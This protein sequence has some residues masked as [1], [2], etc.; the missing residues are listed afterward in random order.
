MKALL[1]ALTI[2]T[3]VIAPVSAQQSL[4]NVS[5]D[6][7]RE[8]YAEFNKTFAGNWKQQ[9][10]EDVT[11]RTSH[12]GSGAQARA[13]IDGLEADVVTLAL[14]YDID[15]IAEKAKLLPPDW[16][17]RLPDNSSP[18]TSTIV[19]LVRAGNPKNIKDWP[20]L[21]KPGVKVITPNPKTSGAARWAYLAAWGYA[22]KAPGGDAAKA[23]EFVRQLYSHVPVL[24][25]GARGSTMTFARRG[26]GD[27][28][29]S[30]ENEA[31]LV[32]AESGPRK[33]E[34]V[35]PSVSILAVPPVAIVDKVVDRRGTRKL[36]QRWRTNA[37]SSSSVTGILALSV[38]NAAPTS[39]SRG[40]GTPTTCAVA[41]AGC[42]SSTSSTSAGA[43]FSPPTRKVSLTRP[44]M[45]S[46][47]SAVRTPMSPVRN[48]PPGVSA[49]A[50][51][52][53]FL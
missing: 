49:L 37:V 14:A 20:D 27:V 1:F 52:S 13:V 4:L 33:F 22:L 38:T 23:R 40:S 50:V 9:T 44:T 39:P 3:A 45:R 25:S 36:A 42:A 19:F 46:R 2:G 5:Y 28:L 34:I 32:I 12:G 17:S 18:Y 35:Q 10:G 48:Q 24:D 21:I 41:T 6:P 29:L 43:T 47:P 8:L 15:A 53:G 26:Q 51:A 30:W 31:H 11:V 16:Q 7:T